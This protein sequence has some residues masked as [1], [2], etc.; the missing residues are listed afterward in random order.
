MKG[1][2]KMQTA[3]QSSGANIGVLI[4]L[5]ITEATIAITTLTHVS[6]PLLST[7]RFALAAFLVIGMAMCAMGMQI[8]Q[9]GWLNPFNIAGI[10]IGVV[11]GAIGVAAF[12]GIPL[13]LV[14]DERAAIL[15]IAVLMI[16]KMILAGGRS[17]V[18]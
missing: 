16:V 11:I 6:L 1:N 14:A 7:Q 17:V 2:K 3:T 9:Y 15:T 12:F 10:V 18:S 4:A 5:G 13:P 8:A